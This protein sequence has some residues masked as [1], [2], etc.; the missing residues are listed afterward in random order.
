LRRSAL[1]LNLVIADI[2]RSHLE[3]DAPP[4]PEFCDHKNCTCWTGYPASRFPNW[5]EPQV[6]KSKIWDAREK[7]R[8]CKIYICD[9]NSA[10]LFKN[11]GVMDA[12]DGQEEKVWQDI[13]N[14]G[15]NVSS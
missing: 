3:N 10:G 15:L 6:R 14:D 9:V 5:T 1:G 7:H 4:I 12:F 8:D 13:L 2:D 11:V